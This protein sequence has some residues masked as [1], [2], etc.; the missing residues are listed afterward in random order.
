M[1]CDNGIDPFEYDVTAACWALVV[2]QHVL[3]SASNKDHT[4]ACSD[5]TTMRPGHWCM[6]S[7]D[8]ASSLNALQ[9]AVSGDRCGEARPSSLSRGFSVEV[10]PC[11]SLSPTLDQ[12]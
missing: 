4:V 8:R 12:R 11:L 1:F 7:D 10:P 6:M 2:I 5:Q 9:L 3:P